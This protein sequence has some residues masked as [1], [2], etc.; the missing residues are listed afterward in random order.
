MLDILLREAHM[1]ST[2]FLCGLIWCI[3][4]V[5]Y[6]SF[7]F[8]HPDRFVEFERFHTRAITWIVGPAM[9]LEITTAVVLLGSLSPGWG[10]LNIASVGA[11][12]ISTALLSVPC[13]TALAKGLD[14]EIIDKLVQT[15]WPRTVLWSLRAMAWF[16]FAMS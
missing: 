3:Q 5:H 13:H 2:F 7:R 11:I 4:V 9:L 6:P 16:V 1:A 8:V 14:V 15:N 12:W 10:A